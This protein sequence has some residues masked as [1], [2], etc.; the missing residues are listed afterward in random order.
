MYLFV[1][2]LTEWF[3]TEE[4]LKTFSLHGQGHFPAAQSSILPA[5]CPPCHPLPLTESFR[6]EKVSKIITQ[7]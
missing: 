5:A 2:A 7:S 3:K 4:T 6:L 1:S